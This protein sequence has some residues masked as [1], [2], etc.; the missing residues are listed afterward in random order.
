ML[1]GDVLLAVKYS[2]RG[3][4]FRGTATK[5]I[6]NIST[7]IGLVL[8]SNILKIGLSKSITKINYFL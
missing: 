3:F 6:A 1:N 7:R 2:E 4:L 5:V 8:W